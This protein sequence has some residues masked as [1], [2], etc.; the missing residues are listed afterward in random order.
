MNKKIKLSKHFLYVLCITLPVFAILLTVDLVTKHL[1]ATNF[2]V[3]ERKPFLPGFIDFVFVEN[4]GAAGGILS[5]QRI[6][7]IILAF[8]FILGI[9]WLLIAERSFNP[10]FHIASA[11]VL[12]GCVG[13]LVD[14][15]SG[16]G[17]VRDFIH[18]EFWDA[19][20]VFNVADI[21]L[22]I[23]AVLFVIY[24]IILLVKN[25]KKKKEE[26]VEKKD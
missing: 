6:F 12:T 22:T 16:Q 18:F 4:P 5:G 7:L 17:F 15:L 19:F 20:P 10:L 2:S 21:C 26:K 11:L 1:V 25:H 3:G 9:I 24:V 23:G 13:N 8:V 14:R